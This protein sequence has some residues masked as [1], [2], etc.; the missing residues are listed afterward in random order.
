MV[1][2]NIFWNIQKMLIRI[3]YI[4]SP[5]LYQISTRREVNSSI[6]TFEISTA[7]LGLDHYKNLPE[8]EFRRILEISNSTLNPKTGILWLHKKIIKESSYWD[9]SNLQ[10]WEPYPYF[11][12]KIRGLYS[13]LPDNGYFHFLV[14]DLPRF[15]EANNFAQNLVTIAGSN[16]R[17]ITE[18]LDILKYNSYIIPNGPIKVDKVIMSEKITGQVFSKNDLNL[19]KRAFAP[20]IQPNLNQSIFIS[21]KDKSGDKFKS[22]GM[23]LKKQIEELFISKGFTI[24]YL[25]ELNFVE[26]INLLSSSIRIAGFHGAGL[27]NIV[28]ANTANIIEISKTQKTRHFEHLS[29]ICSH[30]YS[31][32]ST[33]QPLSELYRLIH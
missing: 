33:L 30:K 12:K 29:E 25:E 24:V 7:Y 1:Y 21:R 6:K 32:Y 26:Q 4:L 23:D 8:T 17:Y 11:P 2:R 3:R 16:A 18:A 10:K 14:E 31:F 15:I 20:Y 19:V 28:W 5:K 13:F 9:I 22:R 27:A